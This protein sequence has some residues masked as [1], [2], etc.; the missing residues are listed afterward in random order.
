MECF[1]KNKSRNPV[2]PLGKS[3]KLREKRWKLDGKKFLAVWHKFQCL[4]YSIFIHFCQAIS[5][6]LEQK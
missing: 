2:K 3:L 4:K 5:P 6:G 1:G